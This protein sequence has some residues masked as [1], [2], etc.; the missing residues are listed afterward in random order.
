MINTVYRLVAPKLFNSVYQEVDPST[1]ELMVRP[2]HLSICKADERYYLGNR[3]PRILDEKLPM[4]LIHEGIGTVVH[5]RSGA[6]KVGDTVV[7]IPNLPLEDDTVVSENYLNSSK[8]RSSDFDGF[9]QEYVVT[10]ADRVLKIDEKI[11]PFV[12]AFTELISVCLHAISRMD[13]FAHGRRDTVG[14]WGDGNVGFI[15]SLLLKGMFPETEVIVF[16]R[17]PE[18]L[19]YF[20]FADETRIISEIPEDLKVDHAFECVGGIKSQSAIEQIIDH[21]NPAGAIALLGVSE[22]PI[23]LNTR[24]ILEKGIFLFGNSRSGKIDFERTLEILNRNKDMVS[25]LE[26]L[27]VEKVKIRKLEDIGDAFE[28]NLGIDFGKMILLWDK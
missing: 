8:F 22:Y 3:D 20:T 16:G 7:M 5:D 23:P 1:C 12:A 14:V 9:L 17:N 25:Y 4:A 15:T 21:I 18:K 27:V 6:F 26:N 13:K 24:M 2:T 28:K 19:S 11:S 10:S